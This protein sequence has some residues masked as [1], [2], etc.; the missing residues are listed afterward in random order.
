MYDF[1][2]GYSYTRIFLGG[3]E[4]KHG[5]YNCSI[6]ITQRIDKQ[7][8]KF[9]QFDDYRVATAISNI[10]DN[11]KEVDVLSNPALIN[12]VDNKDNSAYFN[13]CGNAEVL[14]A[15][16]DSLLE[17]VAK[18]NPAIIDRLLMKRLKND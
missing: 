12:V 14:A 6:T 1:T 5:T 13:Y 15:M 18:D 9:Y 3:E 4:M 17:I 11:I 16:L 10:L 7:R 8:S 2:K